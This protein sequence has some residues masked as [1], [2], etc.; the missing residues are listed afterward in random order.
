MNDIGAKFAEQGL[1][2]RMRSD[3]TRMAITTGKTRHAGPFILAQIEF[4]P[5]E[6]PY[7]RIEELEIVSDDSE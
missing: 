4:G 7:K 1:R 3:P 6:K 5:N 2:V